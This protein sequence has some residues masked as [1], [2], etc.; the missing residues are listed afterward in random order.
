MNKIR[1]FC[2]VIKKLS[3]LLDHRQKMK[4]INVFIWM[5]IASVFE[6]IGVSIIMP[7][8]YALLSPEVLKE[9]WYVKMLMDFMG[10]QST[11]GMLIMFAAGMAAAYVI[12]NVLLMYARYVQIKYQ[13]Q[14]QTNLSL[15]ILDSD[16]KQE[17]S[18]FVDTN[19][20][21][22]LRNIL[23]DPD[24]IFGIMQNLFTMLA[25][26]ITIVLMFIYI[27]VSDW[28]MAVGMMVIAAICVMGITFGLKNMTRAGG[29]RLR[30]GDIER[31]KD[32]LHITHGIKD[33]LVL[34]RKDYFFSR[35]KNSCEDYKKAKVT[36]YTIGMVPER[37]I[38]TVLVAGL[39]GIICFRVGQGT[40]MDTFVPK[41]ASF[42]MIA[43]RLLPSI[44]KFVTGINGIMYS[45]PAL[46]AAY[47][48][49]M[50][51]KKYVENRRSSHENNK[52]YD[53]PDSGNESHLTFDDKLETRQVAWRYPGAEK[54]VLDNIDFVVNK[55]DA[56]AL[57]G[58]SGSG[59]TTLA[60]II[61]GLYEPEQG[62]VLADGRNIYAHLDQWAKF[63]SYVPQT[64]YLIDDT[65]RNNVIFG[66]GF[67]DDDRVWDALE[68]AQIKKYIKSLPD[69]LD[70]MIGEEGVKLSGGQRQRLAIA[71]ALYTDPEILL[72]DEATAALDNE[73]ET[74]VMEAIDSLQGKKTLI[75]IAHRL[76]TIKNCNKVY[77]VKQG[78]LADVTAQYIG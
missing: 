7:F 5:I 12:K 60:D 67:A 37:L 78:K 46:D 42:A 18:Y 71:R 75:I 16:M 14:V 59:K 31:N 32:L 76:S 62:V 54:K 13:C 20:A 77:E 70:T 49:V 64:I 1:Y 51:A 57:I 3:A 50:L 39:L 25:E 74:A 19:S 73:T 21:E 10:I 33:I 11:M 34:Q 24:N 2:E 35:F 36:F 6:M 27:I 45:M 47:D 65:V 8:I 48:N 58:E 26:S 15:F 4:S 72:L 56:V 40:P 30:K 17:Y 53:V 61:L 44:N 38:E 66:C 41:L 69:G 28:V 23:A 9:K 43:F 52:D 22:I 55:G 63:I 29:E 68:Q